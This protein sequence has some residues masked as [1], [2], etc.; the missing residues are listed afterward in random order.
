MCNIQALVTN[1]LLCMAENEEIAKELLT[2]RDCSQMISFFPLQEVL[3]A[4]P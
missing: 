4:V 2:S 1:G 3:A